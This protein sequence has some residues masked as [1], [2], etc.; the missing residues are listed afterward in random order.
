MPTSTVHGLMPPRQT[1]VEPKKT[2][3]WSKLD[4]DVCMPVEIANPVF[5]HL[6]ITTPIMLSNLAKHSCRDVSGLGRPR[7]I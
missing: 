5:G 2:G 1:Y 6:I 7:L 4:L 3:V